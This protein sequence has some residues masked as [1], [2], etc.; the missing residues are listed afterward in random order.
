MK[1]QDGRSS[2]LDAH[3]LKPVAE[4]F[5]TDIRDR[6]II[7]IADDDRSLKV[8]VGVEKAMDAARAIGGAHVVYLVDAE[9]LA[10][11]LTDFNDLHQHA[12]IEAVSRGAC[13]LG[14]I[15]RNFRV[16]QM[17]TTRIGKA[18]PERGG[19]PA[20]LEMGTGHGRGA[21][22]ARRR[23]AGQQQTWPRALMKRVCVKAYLP[24]EEKVRLDGLAGRARLSSSEVIRRLVSGSGLPDL[25]DYNAVR[26]LLKVN[27][28][29]ARLGNLLK[30]A[31]DEGTASHG[32]VMDLL[33]EIRIRQGEIKQLVKAL[34]AEA[35][36]RR[37]NR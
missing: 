32:D 31:I 8:N 34:A 20:L 2:L 18:L 25:G 9:G 17:G 24:Q 26:D 7:F 36:Q 5:R 22:P 12:G 30:L 27:A 10:A 14:P 3:N 23:S 19:G 4:H 37:K 1:R 11:G 16:R 33:T 6:P 13:R 15:F 21:R 35:K 29:L 28:D